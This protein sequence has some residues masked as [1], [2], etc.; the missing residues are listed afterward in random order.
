MSPLVA[1]NI[2]PPYQDFPYLHVE[3]VWLTG[4]LRKQMRIKPVDVWWLRGNTVQ[5]LLMVKTVQN[6]EHYIRDYVT[7]LPFNRDIKHYRV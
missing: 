1:F 6:T 3:D 5:D 7:S 4:L 2:S